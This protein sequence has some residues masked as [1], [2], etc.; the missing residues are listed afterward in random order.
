MS[1][2]FCIFVF[3]GLVR[4]L[5]IPNLVWAFGSSFS[6]RNITLQTSFTVVLIDASSQRQKGSLLAHLDLE[7]GTWWNCFLMTGILGFWAHPRR[8]S[9]ELGVSLL[10]RSREPACLVLSSF[11]KVLWDQSF[12]NERLLSLLWCVGTKL[13]TFSGLGWKCQLIP[14]KGRAHKAHLRKSDENGIQETAGNW[15]L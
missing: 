1:M 5:E 15:T 12:R 7:L 9:G 10:L 13:E 11:S 4:R 3:Y 2:W 6:K 8:V 14:W